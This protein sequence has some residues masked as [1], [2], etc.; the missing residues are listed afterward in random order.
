[1]LLSLNKYRKVTQNY[2]K[3]LSTAESIKLD[4]DLLIKS[5]KELIDELNQLKLER[6]KLNED[7]ETG[8]MKI[9]HLQEE[10]K[11]KNN[12]VSNLTERFQETVRERDNIEYKR[13]INEKEIK[14]LKNG[15]KV[16]C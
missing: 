3:A 10:I 4:N 1:M 9:K 12:F 16:Y 5:N 15:G 7:I 2:Q 13:Q 8:E 14:N 6:I 11:G